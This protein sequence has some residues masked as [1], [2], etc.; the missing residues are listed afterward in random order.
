MQ[1]DTDEPAIHF[2]SASED[3]EAFQVDIDVDYDPKDARWWKRGEYLK[4]PTWKSDGGVEDWSTH[5]NPS[6]YLLDPGLWFTCAESRDSI[7]RKRKVDL[8]WCVACI[9]LPAKKGS[10]QRHIAIR[11]DLDL[12]I[13]Q[14]PTSKIISLPLGIL[15]KLTSSSNLWEWLPFC[16]IE[17]DPRWAKRLE[18]EDGNGRSKIDIDN[19]KTDPFSR[20]LWEVAHVSTTEIGTSELWLVDHHTLKPVAGMTCSQLGEDRITFKARG[21]RYFEVSSYDVGER[22]K[23]AEGFTRS[24]NP[25]RFTRALEN[26]PDYIRRL[27]WANLGRWSGERFQKVSWRVAACIED[28]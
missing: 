9:K 8:H 22:W 26:H 14:I 15:Q 1:Y 11:S 5:R 4:P 27:D 7:V 16:G 2:F 18:E 6:G 28:K 3:L 10:W 25:W 20:L 17:Y 19:L 23:M 21:W 12:I 24:Q 13:F